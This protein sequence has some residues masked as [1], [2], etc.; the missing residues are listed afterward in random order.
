[1]AIAEWVN[2]DICD[3]L[4]ASGANSSTEADFCDSAHVTGDASDWLF[5]NTLMSALPAVVMVPLYGA[6]SDQF[7]R[8]LVLRIGCLGCL[9][10]S[11]VCVLVSRGHLNRDFIFTGSAVYGVCGSYVANLMAVFAY[12]A[13][14]T[15]GRRRTTCI[16]ILE[17]VYLGSVSGGLS[18]GGVITTHWGL[19]WVFWFI[20]GSSACALLLSVVLQESLA[21]KNRSKLQLKEANLVHAAIILNR[22]SRFR[23]LAVA[24]LFAVTPVVSLNS[25]YVLYFKH[26]YNWG[27]QT[28]GFYLSTATATQGIGLIVFLPAACRIATRWGPLTLGM[29]EMARFLPTARNAH[30]AIPFLLSGGRVGYIGI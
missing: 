10:L 9:L 8:R 7:G 17:G 18:L 5:T 6:I 23:S 15:Q 22:D 2:G 16:T 4:K 29:A 28:V 20:C 13:D 21:E 3:E 25:I 27:S 12:V 11:I 14:I 30:H 19:T 1:M 24:F 26:I